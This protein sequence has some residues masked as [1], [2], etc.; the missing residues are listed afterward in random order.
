MVVEE[1]FPF[2]EHQVS[3]I[4]AEMEK[5]AKIMGKLTRHIPYS[6]EIERNVLGKALGKMLEKDFRPRASTHRI[7][8]G[9]Q[10]RQNEKDTLADQV[11]FCPGCL[12]HCKTFK[13]IILPTNLKRNYVYFSL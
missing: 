10:I 3:S 4:A 5:H 12:S 6:N 8:M 13:P 7:A 9:R 1:I 11:R 2:I